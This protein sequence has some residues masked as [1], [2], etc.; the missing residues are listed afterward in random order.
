[1]PT[2]SWTS[3]LPHIFPSHTHVPPFSF[4]AGRMAELTATGHV[5]G[6]GTWLVSGTHH[7]GG[8]KGWQGLWDVVKPV[9]WE[10]RLWSPLLLVG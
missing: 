1:M 2:C 7:G 4:H 3:A 5:P 10:G 6:L 8:R 9:R